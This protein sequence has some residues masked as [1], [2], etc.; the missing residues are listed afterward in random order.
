MIVSLIG[1][2]N[3]KPHENM[4][5]ITYIIM[6]IFHIFADLYSIACTYTSY[7]IVNLILVYIHIHS[8]LYIYLYMAYP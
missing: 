7:A 6:M 4:R 1:P 2:N 8:Y 3:P 5:E